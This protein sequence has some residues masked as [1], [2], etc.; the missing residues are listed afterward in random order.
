[1]AFSLG[2]LDVLERQPFPGNVREL[3]HLV[4]RLSVMCPEE[5]I[6]PVHLPEEYAGHGA[7]SVA[8]PLSGFDGTL[9][10]MT[11]Q[12]ERVALL[13]TQERHDGHRTAA[14]QALGISRKNLWEKL[15]A[16]G[17]DE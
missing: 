10:E 2:T 17:V 4:E 5:T 16:L 1:M 12:F 9:A 11:G 14:A 13:R 7:P 15:K 3:L 8:V 6:S